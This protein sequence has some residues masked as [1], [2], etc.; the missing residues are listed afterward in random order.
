MDIGQEVD[1]GVQVRGRNYEHTFPVGWMNGKRQ[2]LEAVSF[3]Y[4]NAADVLDKAT[5]WSG[6][7]LNL[8]AED[9]EMTSVV[10]PPSSLELEPAYAKALAILRSAPRMRVVL[11]E[12]EAERLVEWIRRDIESQ[13]GG[14]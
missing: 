5:Q 7:L 2:V 1:R 6:R 13:G 9:F 4:L 11:P 3:D 14:T 10:S 8:D 12:K